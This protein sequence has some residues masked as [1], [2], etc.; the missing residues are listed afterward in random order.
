MLQHLSKESEKEPEYAHA[1]CYFSW[2]FLDLKP[3]LQKA[4]GW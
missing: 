4:L 3:Q 1:S 2:F